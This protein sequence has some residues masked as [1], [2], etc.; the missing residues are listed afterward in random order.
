MGSGTED[1]PWRDHEG[2]DGAGQ[3]RRPTSAVL[4]TAR[5]IGVCSS[6]MTAMSHTC[7]GNDEACDK[8]VSLKTEL[9]YQNTLVLATPFWQLRYRYSCTFWKVHVPV[10]SSTFMLRVFRTLKVHEL[11][12]CKFMS[13]RSKLINVRS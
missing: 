5:Q 9:Y 8:F 13:S 3:T 12:L 6:D 7:I 11:N 10:L 1:T 2:D 4:S